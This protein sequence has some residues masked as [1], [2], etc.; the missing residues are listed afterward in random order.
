[1]A[2]VLDAGIELAVGEGASAALAELDVGFGVED[3]AAP[4][5]PG[6][7]GALADQFAAFEDERAE[8]H[9]GQDEGSHQAAGAGADDHGTFGGWRC[10]GV[11]SGRWCPGLGGVR[12]VSWTAASSRTV[13]VD[14]VDE[15]DGGPAAGVVALPGD[16]EA[17]QVVGRNA[18]RRQDGGRGGRRGGGRAGV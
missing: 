8:A 4:E 1:M 6:V 16:G 13:D 17:E 18:E 12:V 9:L 5:A 15:G 14:G 11:G 3:A 2:R 10:T 7:A